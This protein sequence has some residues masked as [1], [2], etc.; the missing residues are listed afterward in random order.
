MADPPGPPHVGVGA[1]EAYVDP[2]EDLM[3]SDTIQKILLSTPARFTDEFRHRD[4]LVTHAWPPLYRGRRDWM[5]H[6]ESPIGRTAMILAFRTE[7]ARKAPGVIVPNYENAGDFVAAALS[8]LFGKRFDAHGP[9]EMSGR[10]GVPDMTRFAA[11]VDPALPFN[12][13]RPRVD[14]PVPLRLAEVRRISGL[15][16]DP[17]SDSGELAIF[18]GAAAFYR[19]ALQAVEDDPEMAYLHLITAG[20]ILSAATPFDE[21]RHLDDDVRDVLATLRGL[22]DGDRM[23]R[24]LLARLHGIKRRFVD[25]ITDL[26]DDGFFQ[27]TEA[28][29]RYAGF[30]REDF[31]RRIKAAYDLRSQHVHTGY[32]FGHWVGPDRHGAEVQ[33]GNPVVPDKDMAKVLKW[34]P[35]VAGLERVIRYAILTLGV[36]RLGI[37]LDDLPETQAATEPPAPV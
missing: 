22:G 18:H 34:A 2:V 30:R 6:Q 17:A 9:I 31:A 4:L 32:E 14:Y 29:E 21:A 3:P 28:V 27:R 13:G 15:L 16:L 7:P 8:V 5:R 19:R 12:A 23:A 25:T 24:I 36:R 11:P 10:Y 33:L 35:L 37:H 20:E 26:V 1:D